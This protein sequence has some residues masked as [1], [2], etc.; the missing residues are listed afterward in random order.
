[1]LRS[2]A[3]AGIVY[4]ATDAVDEPLSTEQVREVLLRACGIWSDELRLSYIG[5]EFAEGSLPKSVLIGWLLE[6]YHYIRDFPDAIEHGAAHANGKLKMC[7][8]GTRTRKG[9]T[10]DSFYRRWSTSVCPG[11]R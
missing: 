3:P 1:L 2:L 5:N 6:M 11:P 8:A 4:S 7:C 9:A 10:K